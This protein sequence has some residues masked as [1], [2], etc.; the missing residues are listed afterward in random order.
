MELYETKKL[1][2]S[3]S[4]K[5]YKALGRAPNRMMEAIAEIMRSPPERTRSAPVRQKTWEMER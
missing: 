2:I 3:D 1:G 4:M 5:F